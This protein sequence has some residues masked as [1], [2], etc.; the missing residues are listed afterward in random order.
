MTKIVKFQMNSGNCR[1]SV[2][3]SGGGRCYTVRI[4][5]SGMGRRG[6]EYL[7]TGQITELS[8][9]SKKALFLYEE[10]GLITPDHIDAETGYRYYSYAQCGKN[11]VIKQMQS[12]GMSI[13]DIREMLEERNLVQCEKLF[14]AQIEKLEIQ[15]Q[16][17]YLACFLRSAILRILPLC[18][19]PRSWINLW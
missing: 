8:N 15:K 11:N 2:L 12:I 10:K 7:T 14:R 13:A 6:M 16:Q 9:I 1:I 3:R 17:I 18:R 5:E 4:S 19:T